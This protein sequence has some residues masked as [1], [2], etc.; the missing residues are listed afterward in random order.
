MAAP[1]G[2]QYTRKYTEKEAFKIFEATLKWAKEEEDCLCV[3]DAVIHSDIPRSTFYYLCDE[4]KVL[5]N[6]KKEINDLVIARVNKGALKGDYNPTAGIWRMKQLG[7][8][9]KREVDSKSSDGSMTPQPTI[10]VKEDLKDEL[11]KLK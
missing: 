9:D 2:N 1:K 10:V 6:I 5:D 8:T 3:Q 4:H 11:E 7:E